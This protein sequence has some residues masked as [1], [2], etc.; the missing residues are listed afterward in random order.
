MT[1]ARENPFD[2]NLDAFLGPAQAAAVSRPR[3]VLL[4]G[5]LP[6]MSGLW[7][8][9]YADRE[10]RDRGPV[11]LLRMERD[12]VQVEV[13]RTGGARPAVRP[14]ATLA[15]A[16]RAVAPLVGAWFIVPPTP[17]GVSIP[18]ATEEV[19]VLTGADEP[20]V[21]AAYTLVKDSVERM[22]AR[23][24]RAG[25]ARAALPGSAP[26]VSVAVLGADDD[27]CRAVSSTLDRTMRAFLKVELPVRG[28]LQRV[29]AVESVLR[30]TFDA[31]EMSLEDLFAEIDAAEA[32]AESSP[33]LHATAPLEQPVRER[34]ASRPERLPPRRPAAT[35][36]AAINGAAGA[37][38]TP[39]AE[40]EAR[41]A[42]TLP[43][44]RSRAARADDA[45]VE[46]KPARSASVMPSAAAPAAAPAA[47]APAPAASATI[48]RAREVESDLPDALVALLDGLAP[49]AIR[50]PRDKS[51]ELALDGEGVLHVVGRARDAAAIL[52][53]AA[54]AREH[55]ELLAMADARV[56]RKEPL[57]D[58]VVADL[59]DAR[60]VDGARV[61]LL[62][63]VEIGGRR[64][65]LAQLVPA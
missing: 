46:P 59:R 14:Q 32:A 21:V 47:L 37:A 4:V 16:L 30:G 50:A 7:I 43:F 41:L 35:P 57:V 61:H 40:L 54:W 49:L 19:V 45:V 63:L 5:N 15:E 24:S 62:T 9:Q 42:P 3:T 2:R 6:M 27:A 33:A 11:C 64:G 20:A 13:F 12:A 58:L 52:R 34:F 44:P 53:V 22:R 39:S 28:G 10:A 23:P 55:A 51:V 29:A 8:S 18:D 48:G 60:A 56:V 25:A 31:R 1:I 36:S 65:Y 38:A 26:R 17:S